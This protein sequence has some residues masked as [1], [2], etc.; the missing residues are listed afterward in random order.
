MK[1]Y[2]SYLKKIFKWKS[3]LRIGKNKKWIGYFERKKKLYNLEKNKDENIK[4]EF[5]LKIENLQNEINKYQKLLKKITIKI[6]RLEQEF[7]DFFL[8]L[9]K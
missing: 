3:P 6:E 5:V 1:K 8:L 2:I 7:D 4:K 9:K